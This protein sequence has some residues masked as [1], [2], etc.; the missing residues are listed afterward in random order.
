LYRGTDRMFFCVDFL[1]PTSFQGSSFWKSHI[2]EKYLR[3]LV[4]NQPFFKQLHSLQTF[5]TS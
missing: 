2:A 3:P 4:A 1:L 5:A